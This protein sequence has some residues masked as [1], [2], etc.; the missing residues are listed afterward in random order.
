[1]S[2]ILFRLNGV[3]EDEADEVRELL[4]QHDMDYYE[5]SAGR[6]GISI[7]AIW[8]RDETQLEKARGLIDEYQHQ[9]VGRVKEEYQRQKTE[10]EHETFLGRVMRDPL[11][12]I[13]YIAVI[14]LIIY[15]SIMPF[16]DIGK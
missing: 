15:L 1:M 14:I 11:H 12:I 10:G 6:W 2:V 8:L 13:F 7:A 9:R 5:T 4:Q 3:P 16:I